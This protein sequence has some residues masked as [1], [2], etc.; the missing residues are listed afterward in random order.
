MARFVD[1]NTAVN[2]SLI[3]C[4]LQL[5]LLQFPNFLGIESKAF[6]H[7]HF[8]PPTTDHH[9]SAPASSTFSS[10]QTSN[11]TIRWR[12]SPRNPAEIQSNARILRWS[13][14]S[15][16]IQVASNAREQ[17]E[18][19]AKPLAPPHVVPLKAGFNAANRGRTTNGHS[20]DSRLDSHTYLTAPHEQAGLIRITNHVT[21]SL[22]VKSSTDQNDDALLKL[23]QSLAAATK[24]NKTAADGGLEII[25]I[26][27]DP[28]LA[29]KKAEVAEKEK[30]RAQR[31]RQQQEERERDRS[32]RALGRSGFRPGGIGAGLTI[33]GLEDDDGMGAS[34]TRMNKPKKPTRRRN[35]E[36]SDDEE[37]FRGMGRTREDEYDENDGFLVPSDEEFEIE[38]DGTED[39]AEIE[40]GSDEKLE[41]YKRG[42]SRKGPRAT[43]RDDE[44]MTGRLKRRRIIE[45]EDEE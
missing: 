24:G 19:A 29:K 20:Y 8:Q 27:E 39:D 23:Q 36:Y 33:G 31:R 25:N 3:K 12:Y 11:N 15:L 44:V 13:D 1:V 32:N 18:L 26:S 5:Y 2:M 40:D 7:T 6:H 22:A 38:G 45:D 42:S 34:R 43:V 17:F 14:G 28:E 37:E 21:S 10:Y 9:S 35:S 41:N 16:T 4:C 30:L